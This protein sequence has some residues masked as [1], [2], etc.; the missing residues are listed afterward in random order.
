MNLLSKIFLI[1]FLF[2]PFF[3]LNQSNAALS[4]ILN[5]DWNVEWLNSISNV[6]NKYKSI[7][8]KW[9][10]RQ[11]ATSIWLNIINIVRWIFSW[12]LVI[13]IVYAWIQMITSM[14]T[15]DDSLSKAKRSLW[16]A[17]TWLIFVNFPVEIYYA[18][19]NEWSWWR[20]NLFIVTDNFN[21][22]IQNILTALEIILWSIVVFI[23]ILEWI[24]LIANSK[25]SESFTKSKQ[26]I[27]WALI[28][29]VF[30]G[31]IQLW[32][33]FL[34]EW[35]IDYWTRNIFKPVANLFLYL[36][37]PIALFFL[38][39]AWYNMIFSNWDEEKAK[40]WKS[41]IINTCIWVIIMLCIYVLLN[42]ISLLKF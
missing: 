21:K 11:K 26:R 23:L 10:I 37:W 14:W 13:F 7:N 19:T 4:N 31:F 3:W 1:I 40:K 16:Y 36:A 2:I 22:L 15:D 41:I 9:D 30:L 27:Q 38:S 12:I 24:K 6:D 5:K 35:N 17:L 39:L 32:V 8:W 25:D 20:D 18:I 28:W 34:R 33:I 29:L 42:D